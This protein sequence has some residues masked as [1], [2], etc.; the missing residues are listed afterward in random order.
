MSSMIEKTA[1][2]RRAYVSE[3][4][5]SNQRRINPNRIAIHIIEVNHSMMN[6]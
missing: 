6:Y 5:E 4:K 1:V 3:M 2:I